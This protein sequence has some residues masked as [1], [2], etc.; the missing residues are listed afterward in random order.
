MIK[1]GLFLTAGNFA[2]GA[3]SF[4]R[5][6]AIARLV[7]VED[8][9][10]ASTFAM[11]V[12]LADALGY[13]GVDRLLLQAKDG[14]SAQIQ[15]TVHLANISKGVVTA[16]VLLLMSEYVAA[17]F[18]VPETAWAYQVLAIG[19]LARGFGNVDR[20]R[21]QRD[22]HFGPSIV[23]EL[24]A[25]LASLVC[26]VALGV[27]LGDYRA[28][29]YALL[30]YDFV[31]VAMSHIVAERPYRVSFDSAPLRRV[32]KFGWPL[33]INAVLLYAVMQGDRFII[34]GALGV[35]MLGLYS[36]A[37]LLV[38]FPTNLVNKSLNSFFLPQ[39][40]RV[41]E[42]SRR[43]AIY[44]E[45]LMQMALLTTFVMCA[46]YQI[47]GPAV[48]ITM[49]GES[50]ASVAFLFL[51]LAMLHGLRLIRSA[52]NTQ[53]IARAQTTN[54]L[55]AN[56]VRAMALPVAWVVVDNGGGLAMVTLVAVVAE[57]IAT[58][59]ALSM[60]TRRSEPGLG[61]G[62]EL[63]FLTL[64]GVAVVV[65]NDMVMHHGL[66][67]PFWNVAFPALL[68]ATALLLVW[69]TPLLRRWLLSGGRQL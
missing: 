39:I 53:A 32:L 40:S 25:G 31:F 11:I 42:D 20:F 9:G 3:M 36:A 28:M 18:S 37:L 27:V 1:N 16:G 54:P 55:V 57:A 60:L 67:L 65:L 33:T 22:M 43:Y 26:A 6:V 34:G 7:G 21:Y 8:F 48:L 29:L 44:F 14:D 62:V 19:L 58:M 4:A 69:R 66:R 64:M 45:L 56:L 50:F 61:A 23:M 49:Y 30:L 63:V 46:G 38:S 52:I 13:T 51:P 68:A 24:A 47:A 2:A 41:Q 15:R 10:V 59:V 35:E 5:N 17:Y 12:G